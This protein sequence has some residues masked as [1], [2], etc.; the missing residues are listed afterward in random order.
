MATYNATTG[1]T[2]NDTYTFAAPFSGTNYVL[3]AAGNFG[4]G[5]VTLGFIDS[6]DTFVSFK[7]ASNED[8]TLTSSGGAI[9]TS[10]PSKLLAV[11][12][13]GSTTTPA[14]KLTAIVHNR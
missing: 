7:N 1:I 3:Y 2:A 9:V 11:R 8:V 5:T 4:G 10:P 6:L 12:V 13:T 14:I